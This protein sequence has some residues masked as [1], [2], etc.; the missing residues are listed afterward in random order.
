[1]TWNIAWSWQASERVATIAAVEGGV[2]V[3]S[4]LQLELLE[5]DGGRRWSVDVPFKV[6]AAKATQGAGLLAAHGFTWSTPTMVRWS[7]R[8]EAPQVVSVIWLLDQAVAGRSQVAVERFTSFHNRAVVS[9]APTVDQYAGWWVGWT[10]S[11]CFGRIPMATSG[12][13]G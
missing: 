13:D 7:T 3:S 9:V 5:A 10:E 4:G 2:L 12:A 8:A 6:H 11:T 1:M